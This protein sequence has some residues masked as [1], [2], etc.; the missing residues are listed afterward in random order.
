MGKSGKDFFD[1]KFSEAMLYFQDIGRN[2]RHR[3]LQKAFGIIDMVNNEKDLPYSTRAKSFAAVAKNL[4]NVL[5]TD[6]TDNVQNRRFISHYYNSAALTLATNSKKGHQ[7]S[8]DITEY[9]NNGLRNLGTAAVYH[10]F[11]VP[12]EGTSIDD[13]RLTVALMTAE[14]VSAYRTLRE[15]WSNFGSWMKEEKEKQGRLLL[16][17]YTQTVEEVAKALYVLTVFNLV[18]TYNTDLGVTNQEYED[19]EATIHLASFLGVKHPKRHGVFDQNYINETTDL[20]KSYVY[21]TVA[22]INEQAKES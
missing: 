21:K 10:F 18:E 7:H 11:D 17:P 3:D 22:E 12:K 19:H 20:F 15:H 14:T 4:E 16:H 8:S 6:E 13:S 2:D 1:G 9:I 5:G